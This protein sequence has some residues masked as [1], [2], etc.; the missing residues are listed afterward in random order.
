MGPGSRRSPRAGERAREGSGARRDHGQGRQFA[1]P[2]R[3]RLACPASLNPS[4]HR[5]DFPFPTP[6]PR[7]EGHGAAGA[8]EGEKAAGD[9]DRSRQGEGR[10]LGRELRP[11]CAVPRSRSLEPPPAPP[12][13]VVIAWTAPPLLPL[14]RREHTTPRR[15]NHDTGDDEPDNIITRD[16][17]YED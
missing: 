2:C 1:E 8:E 16:D 13:P 10:E 15:A 4:R 17:W 3:P 11:A 9:K 5:G 12:Y 14:H 7:G 6:P